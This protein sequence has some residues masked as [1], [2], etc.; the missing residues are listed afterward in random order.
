MDAVRAG[1]GLEERGPPCAVVVPELAFGLLCGRL[2]VVV[3]LDGGTEA[4]VLDAE[5]LRLRLGWSEDHPELGTSAPGLSAPVPDGVARRALQREAV[6][7]VADDRRGHVEVHRLPGPDGPLL[8]QHRADRRPRV[9]R[10]TRL[11]PAV[12]RD[13]ADPAPGAA[14]GAP[15][16]PHR[17]AQHGLP[18]RARADAG[19]REAQERLARGRVAH[20]EPPGGAEAPTARSGVH[21]GVGV[22][23]ERQ[24][25]VGLRC[26][27][28]AEQQ[29]HHE[30]GAREARPRRPHGHADVRHVPHQPRLDWPQLP[31]ACQA[32]LAGHARASR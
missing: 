4:E 15:P 14:R 6:G 25:P 1:A 2:V 32:A 12:V 22:G 11:G 30:P 16:G 20:P 29:E 9:V 13:Q 7:A 19:D 8:R 26:G 27:G 10:R 18:D 24:H 23:R 31:E 17:E 28:T 5:H 3:G 21:V